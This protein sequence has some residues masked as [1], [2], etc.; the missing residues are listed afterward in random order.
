MTKLETTKIMFFVKS[1][2]H[3]SEK[4][5]LFLLSDT[6]GILTRPISCAPKPGQFSY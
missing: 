6:I 5:G 2:L 3:G 4:D 1:V